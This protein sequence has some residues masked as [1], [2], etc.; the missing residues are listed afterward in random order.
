MGVREIDRERRARERGNTGSESRLMMG[1]ALRWRV[2]GT[3]LAEA[4]V[5]R[6]RQL[7]RLAE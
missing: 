6:N 1:K 3:W 5:L 4:E 2:G 7:N